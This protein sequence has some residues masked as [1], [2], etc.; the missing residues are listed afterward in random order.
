[1]LLT[2]DISTSSRPWLRLRQTLRAR[3]HLRARLR[4]VRRD[5]P[6]LP[7]RLREL[8]LPGG[9][10]HCPR[11]HWQPSALT[12]YTTDFLAR[13]T[14]ARLA[15]RARADS[16]TPP[17]PM[18]SPQAPPDPLRLRLGAGPV[19]NMTTRSS[20]LGSEPCGTSKPVPSS[21]GRQSTAYVSV[22]P[23]RNSA[24]PPKHW[25]FQDR[26]WLAAR[27]SISTSPQDLPLP[28]YFFSLPSRPEGNIACDGGMDAAPPP[29]VASAGP[30]RSMPAT[31]PPVYR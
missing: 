23:R 14:P 17:A 15:H 7:Q 29:L 2:V 21:P 11:A 27:Y 30:P 16:K 26:H 20:F 13:L 1:M 22:Q 3:L 31:L 8:G 4:P 9:S 28:F 24:P 5:G 6:S 12:R 18:V 10:P 25:S 19:S